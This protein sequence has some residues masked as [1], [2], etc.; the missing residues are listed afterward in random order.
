MGI[1]GL[2]KVWIGA[3]QETVK[4]FLKLA[5]KG[6]LEVHR[7]SQG[8]LDFLI[9]AQNKGE[10]SLVSK[11]GVGTMIDPREG[12][13]SP[14]IKGAGESLSAAEGDHLRYRLPKITMAM[15]NAPYADA[16]GNIYFKHASVI[17]E[18]IESALA[19]RQNGGKVLV[20]VTDI[21]PKNEKE[22]SLPADKVDAIV[23]NP[24][25]EQCGMARQR[26]YWEMFTEGA[27]VDTEDAL[28]R[29]LL[30]NNLLRITPHRGPA[31]EALARLAADFFM[32]VAKKNQYVNV[33][34]GMP[35]EVCMLIYEGGIHE[36]VTYLLESGPLGGMPAMGVFFGAS[37]NP[38]KLLSSAQM[39]HLIYEKLDTTLLGL[40]QVDS[41][42]NVNVSKRGEGPINYVGPGG[43]TDM[44]VAAKT[45]LFIGSWMIGAHME[46]HDGKIMMVK[47]G[48]PKFVDKVDEITFSGSEAL[49]HGKNVYY[50]TNVGVFQ[51]TERGMELI[52]VMPGIDI[53][54]DIINGCS[55]K[56]VP[57]EEG[58]FSVVS[59]SI[60]TGKDFKL[61]WR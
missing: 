37:I 46:V 44:T 50:C 16:E 9:E 55:M 57:P 6:K 8:V 20:T 12:N 2:V 47:P 43:F 61:H 48:T 53:Q 21:I 3:H 25:N 13:G 49:K 56:I 27:K 23:V 36:D 41:K 52:E 1:E 34:V 38:E 39:F 51:L 7:I 4:S 28:S 32:R 59:E 24:N 31:E 19:A 35:E 15:M 30:V 42:G 40:L 45:I 10:D 18:N 26:K 11:T 22:I 14:L 5:Q 60:V 17:T 54:K 58:K 29:L 33:G